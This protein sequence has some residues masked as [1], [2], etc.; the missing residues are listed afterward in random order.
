MSADILDRYTVYGFVSVDIEIFEKRKEIVLSKG[1]KNAKHKK[2]EMAQ[3]ALENKIIDKVEKVDKAAKEEE[4]SRPPTPD[5]QIM[6][7]TAEVDPLAIDSSYIAATTPL[8]PLSSSNNLSDISNMYDY[9]EW[10]GNFIEHEM[11]IVHLKVVKD[12]YVLCASEDGKIFKYLL[13]T[14]EL[15]DVFTQHNEICNFF[16]YDDTEFV[17]SASSDG[18]MHK[19]RLKVILFNLQCFF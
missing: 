2:N 18:F 1:L 8:D 15:E 19:F 7:S 13:E 4:H 14:S 17:Y 10:N 11:P 5:L 16:I 6:D 12:K 3:K 9:T